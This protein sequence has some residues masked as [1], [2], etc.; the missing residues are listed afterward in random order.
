MPNNNSS[1]LVIGKSGQLA[2]ALSKCSK[3]VNFV[4]PILFT[5]R[6]KIDL[7]TFS[8]KNYNT[9]FASLNPH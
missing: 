1:I 3:E 6:S 2:S 4:R 7:K 5:S 9:I 8:I